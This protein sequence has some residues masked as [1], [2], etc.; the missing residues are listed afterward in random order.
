VETLIGMTISAIIFIILIIGLG[1]LFWT[2]YQFF[3]AYILHVVYDAMIKDAFESD[4]IEELDC[5]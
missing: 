3:V 1:Y 5:E 4:I 2:I